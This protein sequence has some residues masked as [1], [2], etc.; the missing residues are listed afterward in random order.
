VVPLGDVLP[1]RFATGQDSAQADVVAP[2]RGGATDA[3]S[4]TTLSHWTRARLLRGL[5]DNLVLYNR[6]L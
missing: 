4:G 5:C 2:G 6:L 1:E 3:V